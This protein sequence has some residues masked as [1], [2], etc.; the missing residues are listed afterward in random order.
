MT[1]SMPSFNFSRVLSQFLRCYLLAFCLLASSAYAGEGL[2]DSEFDLELSTDGEDASSAPDASG[3]DAALADVESHYEVLVG[4]MALMREDLPTAAKAYRSLARRVPRTD[5]IERALKIARATG[6]YE[7]GMELLT[8]WQMN[9]NPDPVRFA[10]AQTEIYLGAGRIPEME[11]PI[12]LL[13]E[14]N[15]SQRE[16]NFLRI[17]R[18]LEHE[19]GSPAAY[20]ALVSRLV[21]RY[22]D[23]AAA[24]FVLAVAAD[25]AGEKAAATEAIVRAYNLKP[26]WELPL[27]MRSD[28]LA[29][30]I[31]GRQWVTVT[32]V[33]AHLE[34]LEKFLKRH[35][36]NTG[37][38]MQL[39][40]LLILSGKDASLAR[41][42]FERLLVDQPDN[43]AVLYSAA[44]LAMQT[45]DLESARRL[46][47]HILETPVSGDMA[48]FLLAQI[49]ETAG[50]KAL[51]KQHY[52]SVS[53]GSSS[54][55]AAR[56][57]LARML[58]PDDPAAARRVIRAS[59]T[60][61][62][63]EKVGMKQVEA[64]LLCE[65]GLN[66][67]CHAALA[68][69]LKEFPD[70]PTLLYDAA[71]AADKLKRWAQ[72]E[73]YLRRLMRLQP[74]NAEA[75]NALGY[76]LADR[77]VR[78]PEARSLI[79]KARKLSPDK[80]HILDSL[81]WVL[82]RQG[83][84]PDALAALE[85]AYAQMNDPEIAAHL[86]E[87]LWRLGRRDEALAVWQK[88]SEKSPDHPVLKATQQRFMP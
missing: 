25:R 82:Y 66:V 49:E 77:N 7:W 46:L 84:L 65:K 85:K 59:E 75:Y 42:Q 21:A 58:M 2:F 70:N 45:N 47:N 6:D 43:P 35:P 20:Y 38:R 52:E 36:D 30:D 78:L 44:M 31:S 40:R 76:S 24:Q 88:E 41:Q 74:E 32:E 81:G 72:M 3:S 10:M 37:V 69:A 16:G 80:P 18:M 54:Y 22:P 19:S 67:E 5:I 48:H 14:A 87:V 17:M 23:I 55:Y 62:R 13:M 28:W 73:K 51:A 27:L 1:D 39:A 11:E 56:I 83:K 15:P 86:G 64:Q 12:L 71:L 61:T 50:D 26:D 60:R 53:Y 68:A 79:E 8:L 29:R 9:G 34:R 33:D 57:R 63:E 4:E